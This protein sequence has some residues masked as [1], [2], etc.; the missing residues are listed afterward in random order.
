MQI[1]FAFLFDDKNR[2][3]REF[4]PSR[5]LLYVTREYSLPWRSLEFSFPCHGKDR[6]FKSRRE[7]LLPL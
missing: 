6:V 3:R 5:F 2:T 4:S 1:P 7:R